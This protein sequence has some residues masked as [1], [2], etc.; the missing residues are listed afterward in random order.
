MAEVLRPLLEIVKDAEGK[1]L[2]CCIKQFLMAHRHVRTG[3]LAEAWGL[4]RRT[5]QRYRRLKRLGELECPGGP[6][7]RFGRKS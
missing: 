2:Y 7:C 6:H 3:P 4:D 1:P 5:I